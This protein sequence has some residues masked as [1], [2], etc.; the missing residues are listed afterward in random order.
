MNIQFPYVGWLKDPSTMPPGVKQQLDAAGLTPADYKQILAANP[1]AQGATA[2]DPNRFLATPQTYPYQ[3]PYSASDPVFT[4]TI[5]LQNAVNVSQ[6]H[7][8]QNQYSVS[9]TVSAGINVFYE[10][11]VKVTGTLEWTN[12]N[13]YGT[14]NTSTQTAAATVGGPAFGYSGPTDVV[15]YWDT[16][17][18]S[19]L[20]AFPSEPPTASGT[21]LD[22]TGKAIAH[23]A[24]TL[25]AGGRTF[26]TFTNSQGQYRFYGAPRGQ[27][28]LAAS[29]Q[30]FAVTVGAGAT[31]PTLRLH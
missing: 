29:G 21:L 10:S 15:V 26:K 27:G 20:F 6:I 13:A 31:P 3:P 4:N 9:V 7:T 22:A 5:T 14:S 30:N 11:Q 1:F 24:V 25:T 12:T 17:Y 23:Q 2:I 16:L 28:S 19:F 18:S 8:V